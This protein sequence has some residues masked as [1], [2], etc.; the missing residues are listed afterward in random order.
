[1]AH[2]VLIDAGFAP[3]FDSAI[4]NQVRKLKDNI[5]P[6]SSDTKDLRS[7]LWSSIDNTDSMDLDQI[8]YAEKLPNGNARIM[9]GI[10][11]VDAYVPKGSPVDIHAGTNTT[12][13]YTGVVTFP[14][15]P[16]QLSTDISSLLPDVDRYAIVI[17]MTLDGT[18]NVVASDFYRALVRNHAKLAYSSLGKWFESGEQN[19]P[20][21]LD[22]DGLAHQLTLQREEL[23]K[24]HELR[25]KHG[26]LNLETVEA[27]PVAVNG[28]VI[29][30]TTT[31]RN[32]A[33]DLIENFMVAA[34]S[35]MAVFL[36]KHAPY[37]IRRIVKEPKRWPRIVEIAQGFGAKLPAQP[38][39]KALSDFLTQR[40][41]AD[42]DHF[43]DLS[44]TIVKL[45]GPGEYVVVRSGTMHEG[46][47]GLAVHDYTH[48]TAP[49]RRYPDLVTQRLLK[50]VIDGKPCPYSEAELE[51]IAKHCT[52]MSA[53]ADKAERFMRKAFAAQLLSTHIGEI[54]KGIVT[55]VKED[56]TYVR[57]SKPSAERTGW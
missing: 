48:S 4:L 27:R 7:I 15:L 16:E 43:P 40:K 21:K 8:E 29:D 53:A 12:S 46:H 56:G 32:E 51:A 13:V 11:D 41:Q 5:P 47:F 10:A 24:L 25:M 22:V 31:E 1:M 28:K 17:D 57:I 54:F 18:G 52:E 30:I 3:D 44:L 50:A 19:L 38:D 37:S 33:R 45:L 26:S 36:D 23:A 20:N 42:P 2:R 34:N 35:A 9:I 39:S 14:M 6:R 55:G 49:N